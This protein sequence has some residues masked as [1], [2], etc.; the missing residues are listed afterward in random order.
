[1]EK[2]NI[3]KEKIS[4]EMNFNELVKMVSSLKTNID[5]NVDDAVKYTN[6]MNHSKQIM[7]I[8][9]TIFKKSEAIKKKLR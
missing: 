8:A 6:I 1:M 7:L 9:K 5:Q 3:D 4:I 2:Y